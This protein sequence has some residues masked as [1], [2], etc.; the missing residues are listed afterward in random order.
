[1]KTFTLE[2]YPISMEDYKKLLLQLTLSELNEKHFSNWKEVYD[3]LFKI[4]LENFNLRLYHKPHSRYY[5]LLG[6]NRAILLSRTLYIYFKM[7]M[8]ENKCH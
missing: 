7:I 3:T 2:D 6:N 1:M 5:Y 4:L 8:E